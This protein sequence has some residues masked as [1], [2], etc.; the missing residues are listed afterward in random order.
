MGKKRDNSIIQVVSANSITHN[1]YMGV[2]K[3]FSIDMGKAQKM[4]AINAVTF[5]GECKIVALFNNSATVAF[6]NVGNSS[7]PAPS[8]PADGF[9]IKPFDY[10]VLSTFDDD[11]IISNSANVYAYLLADDNKVTI[12]N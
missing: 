8:S 7:V 6:V 4:G 1:P 12:S 3:V 5:V 10:L 9:P 11:Y 2:T